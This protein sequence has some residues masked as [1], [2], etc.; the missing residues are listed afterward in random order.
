MAVLIVCD[1]Q[2]FTRVAPC[3]RMSTAHTRVCL[4][5]PRMRSC[6]VQPRAEGAL[7]ANRDMGGYGAGWAG[8]KRRDTRLRSRVGTVVCKQRALDLAGPPCSSTAVTGCPSFV[9]RRITCVTA[10][11]I[12]RALLLPGTRTV[13]RITPMSNVRRVPLCTL[14]LGP[15]R[16]GE[17]RLRPHGR[18]G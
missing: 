14:V 2:G 5:Q 4:S 9:S 18:N 17:L 3:A 7:A 10:D 6:P 15:G 13:L 1:R 8:R 16:L 12:T 11:S